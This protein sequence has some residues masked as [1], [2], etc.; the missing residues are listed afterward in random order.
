MGARYI[1]QSAKTCKGKG[2]H[3]T[4]RES[5]SLLK[6]YPEMMTVAEVAKALRIGKNKAYGLVKEGKLSALRLGG[7][8]IVP[9]LCLVSF[10]LDTKNYQ[11]DFQIVS[12][13]L[14]TLD[15]LCGIICNSTDRS[16]SAN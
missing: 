16:D 13:N 15:K 11:F 7:K 2:Y 5:L 14:W 4:Q 10:I 3:M 8:V 1:M 6:E 12:E 9:K